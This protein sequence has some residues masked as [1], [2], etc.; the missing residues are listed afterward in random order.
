MTTDKQLTPTPSRD[1]ARAGTSL[2]RAWTAVGLV[3]VAFLIAFGLGQG[4]YAVLG[5]L[6]ED[7]VVPLWVSLVANVPGILLFLVPCVAAVRYGTRA[8]AEGRRQGWLPAALGAILGVWMVV[9][10]TVTLVAGA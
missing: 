8:W 2:A 5:Y 4:L 7:A 1:R 3:P 6:P 10:G 9:M